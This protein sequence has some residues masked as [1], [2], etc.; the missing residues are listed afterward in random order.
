LV[1]LFSLEKLQLYNPIRSVCGP[2]GAS[3]DSLA[4][5][6][7]TVAAGEPWNYDPAVIEFPW[8]ESEFEAAAIPKKLTFGVLW[9]DGLVK[10]IPTIKRHLDWVV[11]KLVEAGHSVIDWSPPVSYKECVE[12][13]VKL[14]SSD[15][16]EAVRADI[17]KS[18]EPLLFTVL[19]PNTLTVAQNLALNNER[20]NLAKKYMDYWNASVGKTDTGRPVD[21]LICP[22]APFT[23]PPH[24]QYSH[25]AYTIPWNVLDYTAAV[26]PVRKVE[27]TKEDPR[28]DFLNPD[29]ER[30]Y[31][32]YE[33]KRDWFEAAPVCFQLVGRR[34]QE[35]KILG[36]LEHVVSKI[37]FP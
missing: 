23:A 21:A 30:I 34:L 37:V 17:E 4:V 22:V 16:G 26:F 24:G 36:I 29:D 15:G 8:H 14:F 31:K 28:K 11:K 3:V 9:D 27:P 33:D 19:T 20:N 5:F 1:L 2:I 13:A 32:L 7:K 35:E 12:L 18:G 6:M 10:P 25:F